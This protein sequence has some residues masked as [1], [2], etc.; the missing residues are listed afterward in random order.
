MTINTPWRAE[1]DWAPDFPKGSYVFDGHDNELA[2]PIGGE[3]ANLIAE[4]PEL[5]EQLEAL[6]DLVRKYETNLGSK[7]FAKAVDYHLFFATS[8][9]KKAKGE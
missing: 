2:G 8:A 7:D 9:I 6:V 1:I 4:A 3:E 5:L